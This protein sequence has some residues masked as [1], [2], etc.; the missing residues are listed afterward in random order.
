M[1]TALPESNP[2]EHNAAVTPALFKESAG[3]KQLLKQTL[4]WEYDVQ[5]Q[6]LVLGFLNQ[7]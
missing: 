2:Q 4:G 7:V 6:W 3:L 5:V 1:L